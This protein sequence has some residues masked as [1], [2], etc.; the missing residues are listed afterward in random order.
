MHDNTHDNDSNTGENNSNTR[1][2]SCQLK[3]MTMIVTP[4]ST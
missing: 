1:D 3:L 2:K 4:S